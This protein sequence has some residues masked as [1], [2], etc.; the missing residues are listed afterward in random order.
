MDPWGQ[1]Y[2]Y[3][4]I[5]GGAPE[6]RPRSFDLWSYGPNGEDDDGTGD[7]LGNW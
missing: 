7:D 4:S 2:L 1:P 6:H 5:N 3:V